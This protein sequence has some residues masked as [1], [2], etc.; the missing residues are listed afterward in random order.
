MKNIL[1]Y[2]HRTLDTKQVF[3]VGIGLPNRPYKKNGRT[4]YW[5]NIVNKHGYSIEIIKENISW[6]D[7][8]ELEELLI[9]EY[10]RRDLKTGT[11]VNLT[12]GG[13]GVK[14]YK[15]DK[16]VVQRIRKQNLGRKHS[17][18]QNIEKSIRQQG[19]G[20]K[21]VIDILTQNVYDS[22]VIASK[23]TGIPKTTLIRYLHNNS[24]KTTLKFLENG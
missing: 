8:C 3:Y 6:T 1:V 24:N 19:R 12:N 2:R 9:L 16:E 15:F 13:D 7:A 17:L 11:L 20:G 10:G 23:K 18:Q 14:N 5:K 22:I 4:L 21:K